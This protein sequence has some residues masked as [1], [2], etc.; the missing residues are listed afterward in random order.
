MAVIELKKENFNEILKNAEKPVLVDFFA[1]WCGPCKM[2]TPVV[3]E[4]AE[5][6]NDVVFAKVNVDNEPDI[7]G[8]FG[9]M[10]IPTLILFKNGEK[11]AVSVG[12]KSKSELEE[13]I[14]Q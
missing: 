8:Q 5:E 11:V 9:I 13:F 3:H 6:N 1:E 2:L 7:A 4:L 10:S 14:K 12:F